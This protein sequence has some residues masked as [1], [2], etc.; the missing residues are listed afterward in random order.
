VTDMYIG[1]ETEV[2]FQCMNF[3]GLLQ[4]LI[5]LW[6]HI[7]VKQSCHHK[8]YIKFVVTDSFNKSVLFHLVQK[9]GLAHCSVLSKAS[10]TL[11]ILK[12]RDLHCV[13]PAS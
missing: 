1:T 9:N 2:G 5:R 3:G 6:V 12:S 13:Q 4:I 8:R 7:I 11:L 10:F